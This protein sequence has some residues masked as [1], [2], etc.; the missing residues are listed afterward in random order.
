MAKQKTMRLY[1]WIEF[2]GD[3]AVKASN[4]HPSWWLTEGGFWYTKAMPAVVCRRVAA[5]ILS[6]KIM[7]LKDQRDLLVLEVPTNV[8]VSAEMFE[9]VD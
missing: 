3:V 6:P 9:W 1:V 4:V 2:E 5:R 7:E 8:A